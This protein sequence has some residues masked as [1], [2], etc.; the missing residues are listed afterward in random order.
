MSQF[1]QTTALKGMPA[2]F[3]VAERIEF[4]RTPIDY[5]LLNVP[6]ACNY[7]CDKCFT[8]ASTEKIKDHLTTSEVLDLVDQAHALGAK[9][10]GILGEGEPSLYLTRQRRKVDYV[11]VIEH[12]ADLGIITLMATNGSLLNGEVLD[13]CYENNVSLAVSID[14]LDPDEYRNFYK[15]SANLEEVMQNL[16]NAKALYNKDIYTKNDCRVHRLGIHMTV[17][18]KN[19]HLVP[20]IKTYCGDEI[21]FDCEHIAK[22]GIA[23]DNPEIY[24]ADDED[25]YDL[26]VRASRAGASPMVKTYVKKCGQD[27]CSL[28]YYGFSVGYEGE[29]LV[30]THA[31]ET[32]FAVGSVREKS[33]RELLTKSQ[34]LR[35]KYFDDFGGHYCIIRSPRYKEFLDFLETPKEERRQE[36]IARKPLAPQV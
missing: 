20:E 8:W 24:G 7:R 14:T 30:D 28:F 15:G 35:D 1:A 32:K 31:I 11:K 6:P 22:V 34:E 17:T 18:T 10:I 4:G 19:Y 27:S 26:C 23:N 5:L 33:V 29:V 2:Y 16:E 21:Y 36:R 13:L 3:E 12:A 25:K 9:T